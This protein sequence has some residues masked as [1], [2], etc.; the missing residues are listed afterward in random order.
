M[1]VREGGNME[2]TGHRQGAQ[3]TDGRGEGGKEWGGRRR[4]RRNERG[5]NEGMGLGGGYGRENNGQPWN[6]LTPS[7]PAVFERT[8]YERPHNLMKA[9]STPRMLS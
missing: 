4:E 5:S 1:E 9:T 2:R 3:D 7:F 6:N 8:H